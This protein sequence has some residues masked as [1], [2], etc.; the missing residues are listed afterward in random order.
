MQDLETLCSYESEYPDL[1][2]NIQHLVENEDPNFLSNK[3]DSLIKN[4]NINIDNFP[5]LL[6]LKVFGRL[7]NMNDAANNY[8]IN[9]KEYFKNKTE[10]VIMFNNEFNESFVFNND[11]QKKIFIVDKLSTTA[12]DLLLLN[13][14]LECFT[15]QNKIIYDNSESN[16]IKINEV[17]NKFIPLINNV[18]DDCEWTANRE[19][20]FNYK[21]P[22]KSVVYSVTMPST[23]EN[24]ISIVEL[25][26][27]K[28]KNYLIRMFCNINIKYKIVDDSK[29]DI[30][31]VLI[32]ISYIV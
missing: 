21:V 14:D 5:A 18:I 8:L 27:S 28:I 23:N 10:N 1:Y 24:N 3:L 9:N 25:H 32:K 31:W 7:K 19:N 22:K 16:I 13:Y 11:E 4:N 6:M 15:P 2:E 30:K 17:M 26:L 20:T 29:Y 12:V